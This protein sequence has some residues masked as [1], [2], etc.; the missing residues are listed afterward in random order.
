MFDNKSAK[1]IVYTILKKNDQNY[2]LINHPESECPQSKAS[3]IFLTASVLIKN[4][5]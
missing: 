5:L 2:T 4:W 1:Q 3:D